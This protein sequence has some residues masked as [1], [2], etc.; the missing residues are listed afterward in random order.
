MHR[1]VWSGWDVSENEDPEGCLVG[2]LRDLLSF[3][4][5]C[6]WQEFPVL[7]LTFPVISSGAILSPGLLRLLGV[8]GGCKAVQHLLGS[9]TRCQGSISVRACSKLGNQCSLIV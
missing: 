6:D 2:C 4:L 3:H 9:Y 1:Y 7:R 8:G 5:L